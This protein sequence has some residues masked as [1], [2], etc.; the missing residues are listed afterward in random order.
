MDFVLIQPCRMI[1]NGV[2]LTWLQ[3]KNNSLGLLQ[4]DKMFLTVCKNYSEK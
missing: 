1:E 2:M 3:K 4:I